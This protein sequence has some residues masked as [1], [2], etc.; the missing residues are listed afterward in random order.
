MQAVLQCTDVLAC[1]SKCFRTCM[2]AECKLLN[3][4]QRDAASELTHEVTH[5]SGTQTYVHLRI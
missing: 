5:R 2:P 3:F 4:D 1:V